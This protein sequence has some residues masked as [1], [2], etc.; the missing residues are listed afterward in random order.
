MPP[1]R[2][3]AWLVAALILAAI[4]A[5]LVLN[6]GAGEYAAPW[7]DV[8]FG[9]AALASAGLGLLLA[10]RRPENPIGWL[11]LANG[12]V[13]MLAGLVPAW[14]GYALANPGSLPGGRVAAVWDTHGWPL[15]FAPI[16]AMAFVFPD[17]RLPSPRWRAVALGGAATF[18]VTLGGGFLSSEPLDSPFDAVEPFDVL[19]LGVSD[20]LLGLGLLG[21]IITFFLALVALITRFRGAVEPERSQIKWIAYAGA[22][23]PL[24]IVLGTLEAGNP[25]PLTDIGLV[26]LE[27]GIPVAVAIAVL[28]Y[29]LYEIDRLISATVAYALLT[30][31]LLATFVAVVLGLGV[32]LGGG[33]AVPTAIATLA[34]TL[35]FRPLRTRVQTEVDRRF[36]P[37]RYRGLRDVDAFLAELREGRS[38]PE[39]VGAVLAGALEDPSLR[40][41]FWLP[42][43]SEHAD[44][45][46][47]LVPALPAVPSGRTPVRRGRQLLGTLVHDEALLVRPALLD[48]V[49]SRAGLAIEI[50]RLRVEV[51]RQLA[52]VEESRARIV[53]AGY[54]ERRR[55]ER[56][57]HDGAQQRLVAVG[58]DLRHLQYRLAPA[59]TDLR[60]G[61]DSA[62]AG[63]SDA[64]TELRELA[65]GVRPAAL[66]RGLAPALRELA[67]RTPIDTEVEV[68][69]E[70]FAR[71]VEAAAYFVAAEGLTN[72]V[73]HAHG[74]RVV[75]RAT[76]DNGRLLVSV[77]DDGSGGAA[78]TTGSG[79]A[80]LD[81]RVSALGGRVRLSS[82]PGGGTSLSAEFPCGS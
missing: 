68:T 22:L 65:R 61:L 50:A 35:A 1:A 81:D 18:L 36:N 5:Y 14:A 20:S 17:G 24:A 38:E 74:S 33:D 63:L 2:T 72:A 64:I 79:L 31:L 59:D 7:Y 45:H 66:D 41:F 76:R 39:S 19:P 78:A 77:E 70:R 67:A 40:L 28:R 4:P 54:D 10:L 48:A 6:A 9:L 15:I 8:L 3:L 32:A 60:T 69:D 56:D 44:S 62:V 53:T 37:S 30:A 75:M 12:F 25:G 11:L 26:L 80:G 82:T 43:D 16:V 34:V 42:N 47:T 23:I 57:L 46:G 13:L 49:V 51:R 29:R 27:V 58:L 73:K 52:E 21:M 55:L 71:D